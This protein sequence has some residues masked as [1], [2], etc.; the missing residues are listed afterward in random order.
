MYHGTYCSYLRASGVSGCFNHQCISHSILKSISPSL[1]A[2]LICS[3]N[4]LWKHISSWFLI[5]F[6][7]FIPGTHGRR[8]T[9]K[10]IWYLCFLHGCSQSANKLGSEWVQLIST[11]AE[12]QPH[13]LFFHH[14]L[15]ELEFLFLS[16]D[17]HSQMKAKISLTA[18]GRMPSFI[19]LSHNKYRITLLLA[20]APF[21]SGKFWRWKVSSSTLN[22]ELWVSCS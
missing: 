7:T 20:A 12:E 5:K 14:Q 8:S 4:I 16:L 11:I 10:L 6:L 21:P 15:C 19:C 17:S 13:S 3:N 1:T 18:A 22:A 9:W 2:W